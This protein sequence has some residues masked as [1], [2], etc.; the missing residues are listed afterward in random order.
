MKSLQFTDDDVEYVAE[1]VRSRLP[2]LVTVTSA[3][4]P[5][6]AGM[7]VCANLRGLR[8]T[9]KYQLGLD[10]TKD[11]MYTSA[12]SRQYF[13]DTFADQVATSHGQWYE[14]ISRVKAVS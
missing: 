8:N 3:L 6:N 14:L 9:I 2:H 5:G 12:P 10:A 7:I 13:L 11:R 4:L 1:R